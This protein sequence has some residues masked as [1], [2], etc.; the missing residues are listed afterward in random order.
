[1]KAFQLR[2][3]P[4]LEP[5]SGIM[6]RYRRLERILASLE[7]RELPED[8]E[9][10]IESHIQDLNALVDDHPKLKKRIHLTQNK[11][12]KLLEKKL[13]WVPKHYYRTL[14]TGMGMAV[15]GI[16]LGAAFGM[17]LGNMAFLGIG[18]PIGM[19]IGL[20][21]G[22]SMDAQAAKEGRQLDVDVG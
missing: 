22:S 7:H 8:V 9:K 11:L 18:I 10:E 5:Q 4:G 1:M 16:P 14:W 21:I 3:R 19:G 6:G 20:A 12:L 13:K 2:E 17:S 15:F